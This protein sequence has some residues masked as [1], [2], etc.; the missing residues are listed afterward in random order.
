MKKILSGL[1][2]F[3]FIMFIACNND[4][5]K[6]PQKSDTVSINRDTA[7]TNN[8]TTRQTTETR[9]KKANKD[10]DITEVN[11]SFENTI[12]YLKIDPSKANLPWTIMKNSVYV[13]NKNGSKSPLVGISIKGTLTFS[14]EG[15]TISPSNDQNVLKYDLLGNNESVVQFGP[16][17]ERAPNTGELA[18]AFATEKDKASKLKI[19]VGGGKT[20][21]LLIPG[22]EV[23]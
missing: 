7:K 15:I 12:I 6:T 10:V 2:A 8:D 4:G 14:F 19:G 21:L 23:Q 13:L 3:V 17:I 1:F 5:N 9:G 16:T 18:F 22:E 20:I 11:Q